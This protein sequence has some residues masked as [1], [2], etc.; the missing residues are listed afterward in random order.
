MQIYA[1][2][3]NAEFLSHNPRI[4]NLPQNISN[5]CQNQLLPLAT[6]M[7]IIAISLLFAIVMIAIAPLFAAAVDSY[8]TLLPRHTSTFSA[9]NFQGANCIPPNHHSFPRGSF[10]VVT[11]TIKC[12]AIIKCVLEK[13]LPIIEISFKLFGDNCYSK[14]L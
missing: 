10:I 7:A 5:N 4:E 14:L 3:I 12:I 6:H 2:T 1:N 9:W 11:I 8:Q 13:S